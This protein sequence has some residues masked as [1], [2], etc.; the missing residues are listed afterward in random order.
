MQRDQERLVRFTLTGIEPKVTLT[1]GYDIINDFPVHI[2]R[3]FCLNINESGLCILHIRGADYKVSPNNV[4][5]IPPFEP[6]SIDYAGARTRTY[7]V[8][9]FQSHELGNWYFPK[10]I[11]HDKAMFEQLRQLHIIAEYAYSKERIEK[12]LTN[13]Q[14]CLRQYAVPFN[15]STLSPNENVI[16]AK[17]FIEQHCMEDITLKDIAMH[18][19]LSAYHFNRIFHRHIGM[20]PYAYLSFNRIKKSQELLPG[21][22]SLTRLAY[23]ASFFDQSHFSKSFK[24]HVGVS[25]GRYLS[26]VIEQ[27]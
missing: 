15:L 4:V 19:C 13:I 24:K 8:V 10:L 12:L 14:K 9:S 22:P 7:K 3:T 2:H 17:Q 11:V 21:E 6:H 20:S 16:Q 27:K 26:K 25:P 18:A 5:I 1:H 23:R